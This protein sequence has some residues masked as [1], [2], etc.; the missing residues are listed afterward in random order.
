MPALIP[1]EKKEEIRDLADLVDVVQDYVKLKRSGRSWKGLC[2]FHDE[3]TPSF[4]VTPDLGIYKCFG[5]GASGDVFNFVMEME[6]I[7]FVE[8]M[9]TLADRYGVSLPDP[10]EQE[11]DEEHHLREGIYHA[12]KYAGVYYHRQLAES[13]DAENARKYLHSR[14]FNPPVIK[15]FGLGYAP[16]GG[17]VFYKAALDSG[18]NESYLQD[19]GLIKPSNRS[20]EF[21][22]AFRGRLMFPI[23]NP[24]GK[25]IAFAGRALD[26]NSNAKYINSPQTKVYNKSEVLYGLNF[27]RNDIRKSNEALLVEGYTDVISL[28]QHD[29]KNAVASSGTSLT[30]SQLKLLNRYCETIVMI[31]DADTAGQ[32]A[33]ERG[34][35]IALAENM[36]VKLLELQENEDPDS[37]V[38]Q[39][40]KESFKELKKENEADFVSFLIH[41]EEVL[42]HFEDP[43]KRQGIIDGVLE[44][45]AEI[46]DE[47][48]RQIYVQQLH[49]L[50]QHYTGGYDKDLFKRLD[51]IRAEKR[52]KTARSDLRKEKRA[53]KASKQRDANKLQKQASETRKFEPRKAKATH[54]HNRPGYEKELIRLMLSYGRDMIDYIG[55]NC[56]EGEFEDA[57]LRTFYKDIIDRY[58][59]DEEISVKYYA[60]KNH[61]YPELVGEIMLEEHEIS[62]RHPEKTGILY[63]LDKNKYQTASSALKEVKRHYLERLGEK[64]SRDFSTADE[65]ERKEI[66]KKMK[67]V[68]R[69]RT[70]LQKAPLH[71]LFPHPET[72][73]KG[74]I[75]ETKF[76]YTMR[77]E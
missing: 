50:T 3:K 30:P 49:K 67:E 35:K 54:S 47:I 60:G 56:G 77:K 37:F 21:Y 34:L 76:E 15:K 12:L 58:K 14:G 13:D 33:M 5:C 42:G 73:E 7:G 4:H 18:L 6:G 27:A 43:T 29:I 51:V 61:P 25:V 62:K 71:E 57:D 36:Q 40:G 26:D 24:A 2:P 16:R 22:D 44:V 53:K 41:K 28:H 1:D 68:G 17:D 74:Q 19:A 46:T 72:D 65:D 9:R 10:E 52:E 69:H 75:N 55:S 23:F 70:R 59:K 20:D 32:T 45:I 66:M 8:S 39:F 31:Y 38:R 63:K 11:S 48:Q 64:L